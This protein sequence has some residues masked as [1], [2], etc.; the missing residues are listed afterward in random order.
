MGFLVGGP[1]SGGAYGVSQVG[2][3]YSNFVSAVD[4][5][6]RSAIESGDVAAA[7]TALDNLGVTDS[8]IRTNILSQVQPENYVNQA[9]AIE[10]FVQSNPDYNPTQAEINSFV[11]E[12]NE[13]DINS[14]IDRYVDD[15]YVDVQEVIAAAAEQGVT[16]TEEQAQEYVGQGPAGH[17]TA[18]LEQIGLELGP[19]YTS[20]GEARAMFAALGYNPSDAEVASYVGSCC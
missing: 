15:R 8:T 18:V 12:G 16:L 17:E 20:E 3:M 11:Q 19:G 7:N 1:V 5:D 4:P 6:V 14:S 9:E 2:D 10:S 13:N